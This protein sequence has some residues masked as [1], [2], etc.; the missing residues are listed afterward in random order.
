MK[1]IGQKL[2]FKSIDL[3]ESF[4]GQQQFLLIAHHQP[5][6]FGEKNAREKH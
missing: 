1:G 6:R 4:I 5:H 2:I 3:S